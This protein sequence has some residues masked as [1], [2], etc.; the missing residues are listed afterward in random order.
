[1]K[2]ENFL[3]LSAG[4]G[5]PFEI[6]KLFNAITTVETNMTNQHNSYCRTV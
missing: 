2:K 4:R 3:G 1:M 6:S 5:H